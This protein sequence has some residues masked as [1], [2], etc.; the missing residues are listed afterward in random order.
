MSSRT[1]WRFDRDEA[2]SPHG[3]VAA[4]HEL[5]AEAGAQVLREGGNAIDAVVTAGF[6]AGVVEPFMSGLGGGGF[7]VAHFAERNERIVV[8]HAM[9][10]PGAATPNM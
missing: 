5:A 10:A 9:V 6:V 4:K 3:V 7:L 2:V 1:T 8:D